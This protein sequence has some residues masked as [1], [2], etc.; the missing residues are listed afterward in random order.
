MLETHRQEA[1]LSLNPMCI[2]ECIEIEV[3]EPAA[4]YLA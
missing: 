4:S 2:Q 3:D 1:R